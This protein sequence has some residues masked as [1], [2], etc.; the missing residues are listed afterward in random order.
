M[1]RVFDD[2]GVRGAGGDGGD[3]GPT[4]HSAGGCE[5]DESVVGEGAPPP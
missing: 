1:D 3:G 5:C 2:T 4:E